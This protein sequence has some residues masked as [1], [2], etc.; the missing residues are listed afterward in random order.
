MEI[1]E[2]SLTPLFIQIAEWIESEI[3]SGN[4]EEGESIPSTNQFASIYGIN[5]ATARK[6]FDLLTEEG[7]IYKKR[8]IGMFVSEGAREKLKD[9]ART[10]LIEEHI[11][12]LVEEAKKLGIGKTELIDIIRKDESWGEKS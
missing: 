10:K 9:K 7:I 11:S 6:G 8:G 1:D 12:K 2:N 3:L 5:P 4:I